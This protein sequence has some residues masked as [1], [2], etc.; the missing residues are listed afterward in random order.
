MFPEALVTGYEELVDG[1]T[2][3]KKDRHVLAAAVRC[4]AH[5]IVS[6]NKKHFPS[7]ALRPYDIECLTADEFLEHQYDLNPD[8]FIKKLIEQA[9]DIDWTLRQLIQKHVPSLARVDH[10]VG[11]KPGDRAWPCPTLLLRR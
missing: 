7:R 10:S 5:A 8:L 2:N 1:M 4:G 11:L 9:R 3:D 6:N